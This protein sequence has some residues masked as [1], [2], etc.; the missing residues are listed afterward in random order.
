[1]TVT[2]MREQIIHR[3][4]P[5]IRGQRVDR[6]P[7]GQVVAIYRSLLRRRDPELTCGPGIPKKSRLHQRERFEQLEMDLNF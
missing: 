4:S 3:Y 7:D 2:A 6:M 5:V 1:M